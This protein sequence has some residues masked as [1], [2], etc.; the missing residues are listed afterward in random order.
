[1]R[2]C[3]R[4]RG[5]G[6]WT[7]RSGGVWSAAFLLVKKNKKNSIKMPKSCK[8]FKNLRRPGENLLETLVALGAMA[9]QKSVPHWLDMAAGETE[10]PESSALESNPCSCA[11]VCFEIGLDILCGFCVCIAR[12]LQVSFLN[13][14]TKIPATSATMHAAKRQ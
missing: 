8:I 10:L 5:R 12:I 11:L 1:M 13:A 2:F 4:R 7:W 6:I 14:R 3:S 9:A